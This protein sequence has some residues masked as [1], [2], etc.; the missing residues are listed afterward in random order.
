M[1]WRWEGFD[2]V[3]RNGERVRYMG[4]IGGSEKC[5]GEGM[6]SLNGMW[7]EGNGEGSG[8]VGWGWEGVRGRNGEFELGVGGRG[9][10]RGMRWGVKVMGAL[11]KGFNGVWKEGN[12]RGR[13]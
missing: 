12:G 6:G 5:D 9:K 4:L 10:R 11:C 7:E 2:G 3:R 1:L 13:G 8:F